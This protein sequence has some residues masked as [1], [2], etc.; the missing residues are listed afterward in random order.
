M[1]KS[2]LVGKKPNV[3]KWNSFLE[4]A[5]EMIVEKIKYNLFSIFQNFHNDF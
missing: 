2:I 3:Q 1:R 4:L 5:G